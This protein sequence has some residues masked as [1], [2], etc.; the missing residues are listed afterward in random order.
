M[1]K[2]FRYIVCIIFVLFGQL[3][4][5]AFAQEE[6]FEVKDVN[7]T[8]WFLDGEEWKNL[9]KGYNLTEGQ[10]IRTGPKS[11]A[12]ITGPKGTVTIPQMNKG[13]VSDLMKKNTEKAASRR[14]FNSTKINGSL[15]GS[16]NRTSTAGVRS[17]DFEEDFE[18]EE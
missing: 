8:A 3:F 2:I 6:S 13:A 1:K 16:K 12:I 17:D 5:A 15:Q 7:G 10:I 4:S 11:Q 14:S 9:E 18:W